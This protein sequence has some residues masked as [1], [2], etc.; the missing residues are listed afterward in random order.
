MYLDIIFLEKNIDDRTNRKVK[1]EKAIA[2]SH[3]PSQKYLI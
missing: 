2:N 1:G 3:L